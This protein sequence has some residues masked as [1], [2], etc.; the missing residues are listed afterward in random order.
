MSGDGELSRNKE[1]KQ[2]KIYL[3]YIDFASR[4]PQR[5][6]GCGGPDNLYNIP[7]QIMKQFTLT[8]RCMQNEVACVKHVNVIV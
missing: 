8:W 6:P 4:F 3:N 1:N 7:K 2:K 5:P